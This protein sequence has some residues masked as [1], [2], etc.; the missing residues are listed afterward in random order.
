[1]SEVISPGA[2]V[3]VD[4]DPAVWLAGPADPARA[5][6]WTAAAVE[7]CAEDFGVEPGTAD[8][9]YL[10]AVLTGFASRDLPA[11]NRFLRLRRLDD[12]PLVALLNVLVGLPGEQ[13]AGRFLDT[14]GD[15]RWYDPPRVETVDERTGLRRA[16]RF[17]VDDD[18]ISSVVRYHRRVDDLGLDVLLSCSGA[19]LTATTRGLPDLDGLARAVWVVTAAGER[20]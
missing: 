5:E 2:D 9:D 10:R 4:Y 11:A 6:P 15:E 16:L 17:K 7:A 18:G 20:R 13:L 14:W 12:A 3:V 8:H 1:M 19:D